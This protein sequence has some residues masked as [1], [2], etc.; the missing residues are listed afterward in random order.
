MPYHEWGDG[1]DFNKLDKAANFISKAFYLFTGER[2]G[3]KEKYGTVRYERFGKAYHV[4]SMILPK[5]IVLEIT[6]FVACIFFF[7]H[8]KEILSD[9]LAHYHGVPWFA[10]WIYKE[11]PW[12]KY[13]T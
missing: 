10:R 8:R 9:I 11:N 5:R 6:L 4:M 3:W 2:L 1:F 7:S 13:N 12:K